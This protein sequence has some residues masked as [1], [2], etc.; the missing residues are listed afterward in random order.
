MLPHQIAPWVM[1]IAH[2]MQCPPDF[3]AVSAVIALAS[4][5]GRKIGIRPRAKSDWI[6]VPNLWGLIVGR[7]GVMKSPAMKAAIAPLERLEALAREAG[8]AAH[9]KYARELVAHKLRKSAAQENARSALKKDKSA[10]LAGFLNVDEPEEPKC[11]RYISHDSTY[12]ALGSILVDNPSGILVHR[13]ELVALLRTLDAEDN[14]A[15]RGFYL[16]AWSGTGSYTFDRIIRGKQH[17]EGACVSL[18]GSTQPG[19]LTEYVSRAIRGGSGD[20]GLMQRFSL[21]V[22]PDVRS[23]WEN[24][25]EYPLT[26]AR[27]NAFQI[28]DRLDKLDLMAIQAEHDLYEKLP[29][30]RFEP[31]AQEEFVRFLTELEFRLRSGEL[32]PAIESHLSK[33]RK[34]VPALALIFHLADGH[35]GPV[36]L[37]ATLMAIAWVGYLESHAN[38]A[39]SAAMK[40]D[41]AA[42]RAVLHRIKKGDIRSKFTARDVYRRG[43]AGL[44]DQK[45]VEAGLEMLCDY[46]WLKAEDLKTGGRPTIIY[47]VNPRAL[48]A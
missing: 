45:E 33:Y 25:D 44:S 30:L 13:D 23:E 16:Q 32:H 9:R 20:D 42:A 31:D 4:I 40:T 14:A 39:Y 34:L 11:R 46:N 27:Q 37:E 12:E 21:L 38:R 3:V 24:V 17:I 26:E 15:A 1:D 43:W 10:N 29:F 22:W 7:P 47:Y 8:E 36:G 35:F 19:R 28:F 18:L 41:L 5:L 6:E 48:Q 2:R